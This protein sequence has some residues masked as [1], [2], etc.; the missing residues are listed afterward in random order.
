MPGIFIGSR[1]VLL[2]RNYPDNAILVDLHPQ[3][4]FQVRP[5]GL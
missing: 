4:F 5:G 1:A 3:T 2:A